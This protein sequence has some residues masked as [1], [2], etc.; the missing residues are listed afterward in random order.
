MTM[1][2]RLTNYQLTKGF[3]FKDLRDAR[4][5]LDCMNYARN[6]ERGLFGCLG[7]SKGNYCIVDYG[8]LDPEHAQLVIWEIG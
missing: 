8:I 7:I 5:C 4:A 2:R 3:K 1:G 6:A